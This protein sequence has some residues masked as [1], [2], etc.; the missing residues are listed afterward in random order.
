MQTRKLL[1][2][3]P[4]ML[5]LVSACGGGGS[6]SSSDPG[7]EN[8][9]TDRPLPIIDIQ[10][11]TEASG[12]DRLLG[13]VTFDWNFTIEPTPFNLSVFFDRSSFSDDGDLLSEPA[14][15]ESIMIC[16][17]LAAG[18]FDFLCTLF[19]LDGPVTQNSS[20]ID[21]QALFIFNLDSGTSGSGDFEFCS[22]IG[23]EINTEGLC[24]DELLNRPDGVVR[25]T[26]GAGSIAATQP[27][28]TPLAMQSLDAQFG[29]IRQQY[30]SISD[31]DLRV[32]INT[33][34]KQ[35]TRAQGLSR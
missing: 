5:L 9:P 31:D 14:S 7:S 21:S 29:K 15:D 32:I 13:L 23:N 12:L 26:V 16:S 20:S 10:T 30:P 8:P 17:E 27:I 2:A 4:M 6:D 25:V 24:V 3:V 28:D 33:A 19:F 34:E 1:I 11:P 18:P 22:S 35:R